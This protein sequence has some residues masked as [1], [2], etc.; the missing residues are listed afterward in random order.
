MVHKLLKTYLPALSMSFTL[1]ILLA[2]IVNWAQGDSRSGFISFIF[3]VFVYL[4]VT[5]ILDELI[6]RIDFKTYISHFIAET[7]V[8]YPI[9]LLF[10]IIFSWFEMCVFNIIF[11]SA[12]Y[13]IVMI[14]IHFYFYYVTRSSTAEINHLL[15]EG[16]K[17]NV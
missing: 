1:I 10:I 12:I 13:F 8:I 11:Y 17:K 2:G 7:L 5:C 9:T 15:E 16:R 4:V 3:E 6:G 14:G